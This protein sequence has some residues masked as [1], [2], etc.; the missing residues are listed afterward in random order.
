M[1]EQ[2][3]ID[4][5]KVLEKKEASNQKMTVS[6]LTIIDVHRGLKKEGEEITG[7]TI[8]EIIFMMD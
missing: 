6:E 7:R 5:I 2:E 4:F 1:T 3:V 8:E